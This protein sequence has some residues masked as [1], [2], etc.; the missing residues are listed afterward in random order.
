[1]KFLIDA[2]LIDIR[3][4]LHYFVVLQCH[5]SNVGEGFSPYPQSESVPFR[6]KSAERFCR[7]SVDGSPVGQESG[8][9]EN[10]HYHPY[11]RQCSEGAI[12]EVQTFSCLRRAVL[13]G[14]LTT[15]DGIEEQSSWTPLS[16]DVESTS[17]MVSPKVYL[18]KHLRFLVQ[19][20]IL[21]FP[22]LQRN[23]HSMGKI[24]KKKGKSYN[25]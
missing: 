6:Q 25:I 10:S 22:Y 5:Q 17:I 16:T 18:I 15:T 8:L 13:V 20:K 23:S 11:R 9:M 1:M 19:V 12:S 4:F 2:G 14:K 21:N 3:S 24:I 7:H